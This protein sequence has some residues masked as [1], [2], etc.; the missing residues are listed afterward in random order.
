MMGQKVDVFTEMVC[1]Y[2]RHEFRSSHIMTLEYAICRLSKC[3]NVVASP[4]L[5]T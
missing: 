1:N 5:S 3:T 2:I 4:I